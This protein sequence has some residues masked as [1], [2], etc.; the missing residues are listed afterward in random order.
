MVDIDVERALA[1]GRVGLRDGLRVGPG[2][3][4]FGPGPGLGR[5]LGLAAGLEQ[6]VLLPA[7]RR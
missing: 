3:L 7:P 6:R 4:G 1:A 2:G 5:R